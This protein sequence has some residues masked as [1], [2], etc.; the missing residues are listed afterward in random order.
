[1]LT[2]AKIEEARVGGEIEIT[3]YNPEHLGLYYYILTPAKIITG[4][5]SNDDGTLND[6]RTVDLADRYFPIAPGK[7]VTVV[8]KER[9]ILSRKYYG[10]LFACS[11]C[12][13]SGLHLTFGE[14][15]PE[16]NDELRIGITNMRDTEFVLRPKS[17]LVKVRFEKF[18]EDAGFLPLP[19]EREAHKALIEYLRGKKKELQLKT[20]KEIEEIKEIDDR[21]KEISI[22]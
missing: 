13:E 19:A 18:P 6:S 21:L 11:L 4:R 17:E 8:F 2:N 9:I 20:E 1:M 22:G 12:I 7:N 5:T 15:E 3:N 16:Y 14:I 10:V